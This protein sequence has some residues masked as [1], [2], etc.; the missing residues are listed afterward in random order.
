MTL[1]QVEGWNL[2]QDKVAVGGGSNKKKEKKERKEGKENRACSSERRRRKAD[3]KL[4]TKNMP[5]QKL[6]KLKGKLRIRK[7]LI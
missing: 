2:K 3:R 6:K 1:F 5:K 4:D 7:N